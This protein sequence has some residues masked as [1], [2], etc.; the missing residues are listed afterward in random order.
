MPHALA[1]K[2]D[3]TIE[4]PVLRSKTMALARDGT[5]H[6]LA[7]ANEREVRA[8]IGKAINQ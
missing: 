6:P 2:R 7:L 5:A 4:R 8:L 1:S 3:E